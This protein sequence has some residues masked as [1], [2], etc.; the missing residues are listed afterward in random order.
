MTQGSPLSTWP[1][2]MIETDVHTL[3]VIVQSEVWSSALISLGFVPL[4][5]RKCWKQKCGHQPGWR[6][7]LCIDG[8]VGAS[9]RLLKSL[10]PRK[11]RDDL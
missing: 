1:P 2:V 11:G 10:P 5:L 9:P 3:F 4:I 8:R 6:D 7:C